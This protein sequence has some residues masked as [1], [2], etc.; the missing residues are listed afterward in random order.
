MQRAIE[1]EDDRLAGWAA[2]YLGWILEGK[3]DLAAARPLF[4]L[5]RELGP[6][7]YVVKEANRGLGRCLLFTGDRRA[8]EEAYAAFIA[9]HMSAWRWDP[10]EIRSTAHGTV[11][12]LSRPR[13]ARGIQRTGMV[14]LR[15]RRRRA[16]IV[17]SSEAATTLHGR[18]RRLRSAARPLA[19]PGDCPPSR[20]D[21]NQGTVP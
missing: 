13:L 12:F 1:A 6:E 3:A 14:M 10:G 11:R 18:W 17:Q 19:R 8:A 20:T 7:E 15:A 2:L 5:A 9:V 4:E 21:A 16:Q